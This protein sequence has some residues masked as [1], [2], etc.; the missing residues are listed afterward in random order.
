MNAPIHKVGPEG[1][2]DDQE[3]ET[4]INLL[5]Q[6]PIT[7]IIWPLV[8]AGSLSSESEIKDF[9]K[10]LVKYFSH[11]QLNNIR[12]AFETDLLPK[13]NKYLMDEL[14]REIFGINLDIGNSASYGN[15]IID[16]WDLYG[17][18]IM[19]I[20][21]KDRVLNGLTVPL[22]KGAVIWEDVAQLI[23][24]FNGLLIMQ[25]AR[26]PERS[27]T[28]TIKDYLEFLKIKKVIT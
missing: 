14:P 10:K 12:V 22:G 20:H 19:N 24:N 13:Q 28:E 9:L 11:L 16:E 1:I 8:D 17:D 27:E 2:T 5:G 23:L 18:R 3:L 21:L 7:T 26:I 6:S 15:S 25:C 4:F